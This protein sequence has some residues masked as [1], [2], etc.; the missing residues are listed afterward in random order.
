M[1]FRIVILTGNH[2]CHNPRAYK[3]AETLCSAGF[4]V[5]VLGGW[6][7]PKLAMR[8][9]IMSENLRWQF[10]PVIDW[11]RDG[12]ISWAKKTV[13]RS[14]R[15]LG[16]KAFQWLGWENHDQLGY[17]TRELLLAARN[18]NADIYIAHSEPQT[19]C[20]RRGGELVL[21]WKTGFPRIFFP[22]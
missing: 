18:R 19:N 9:Q 17:C 3:E 7:S 21:I 22:K 6:V 11:T 10:I 12:E 13:Q 8:D 14:R 1:S 16:G 15:W 20:E 5:E 2:L 4:E